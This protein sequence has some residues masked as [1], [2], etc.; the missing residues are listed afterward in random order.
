MAEEGIGRD[1]S[2]GEV[3]GVKPV[4][5]VA[6]A[7]TDE[8]VVDLLPDPLAW[9]QQHSGRSSTAPRHPPV[10]RDELYP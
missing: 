8:P 6:A 1:L 5:P 9:H 2:V 4:G 7:R 3:E 10:R